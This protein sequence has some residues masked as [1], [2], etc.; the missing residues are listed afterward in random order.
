[1]NGW[2]VR[3]GDPLI[4]PDPLD[5]SLPRELQAQESLRRAAPD[6][7]LEKAT[8]PTVSCVHLRDDRA[9]LSHLQWEGSA[10]E[11]GL[12][13]RHGHCCSLCPHSAM[14]ANAHPSAAWP[15]NRF[16]STPTDF[17]IYKVLAFPYSTSQT[18]FSQ[19]AYNMKERECIS[20]VSGA[21]ALSNCHRFKASLTTFAVKLRS[22]AASSIL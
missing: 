8:E 3:N 1:M 16:N 14:P 15:C 12:S 13:Q 10:N 20:Q 17:I 2:L 9:F 22:H 19:R 5:Q 6:C 7:D 21:I 4:H 11:K 18:P